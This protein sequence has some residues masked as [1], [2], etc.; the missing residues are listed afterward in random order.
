MLIN[1]A[2]FGR[3]EYSFLLVEATRNGH[4]TTFWTRARRMKMGRGL[5]QINPHVDSKIQQ[6]KTGS[7]SVSLNQSGSIG[8]IGSQCIS[9]REFG[10]I[11]ISPVIF[12]PP[13][14]M[15]LFSWILLPY[16]K[17]SQQ[18]YTKIP[19]LLKFGLNY[20]FYPEKTVAKKYH[21]IPLIS[22]LMF[23]VFF[24]DNSVST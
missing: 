16:P 15:I 13:L 2:N 12:I 9:V 10:F 5:H 18:K 6:L 11:P 8:S 22:I 7:A 21:H 4:K 1:Q 3:I 23:D 14:L 17:D 20:E 24:D 19:V